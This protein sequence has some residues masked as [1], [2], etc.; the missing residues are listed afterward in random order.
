ML[1]YILI[2]IIVVLLLII[3]VVYWA[4]NSLGKEFEKTT[5]GWFLNGLGK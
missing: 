2:G 5:K 4:L 1:T 3:G